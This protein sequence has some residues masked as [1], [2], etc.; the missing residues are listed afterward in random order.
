MAI[1][2]KGKLNVV[3][4]EFKDP[5]EYRTVIAYSPGG[6]LQMDIAEFRQFWDRILG[7]ANHKN[8]RLHDY[9]LIAIDVYSRAGWGVSLSDT[10]NPTIRDGIMRILQTFRETLADAYWKSDIIS[11]DYQIIHAMTKY[12]Q[13]KPYEI[14]PE[15]QG[16][17]M[18][19]T[20]PEEINKNAIVERFIR[21]IKWYIIKLMADPGLHLISNDSANITQQL[22]QM[23][24]VIHNQRYVIDRR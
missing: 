4:Y 12:R 6:I 1:V 8:L 23:A 17:T 18:Y 2:P 16:I 11:G 15:F 14:L 9:A 24:C 21:T 10:K 3:I 7:D 20:T 22:V 5:H 13:N 19:Q